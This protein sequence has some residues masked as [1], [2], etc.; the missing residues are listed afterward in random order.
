MTLE[1]ELKF[2][3]VKV[4]N[5]PTDFYS[6]VPMVYVPRSGLPY[7]TVTLTLVY[8]IGNKQYIRFSAN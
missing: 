5:I 8:H 6:N 7:L 1:E 4:G 3:S 2:H